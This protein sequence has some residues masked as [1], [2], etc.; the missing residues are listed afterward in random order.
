MKTMAGGL[1]GGKAIDVKSIMEP[2]AAAMKDIMQSMLDLVV[3]MI[4]QLMAIPL[5]VGPKTTK[6]KAEAIAAV[7]NAVASMAKGFGEMAG[8]VM[9]MN[10]DQQGLFSS[11]PTVQKTME[12]YSSVLTTIMEAVK[13]HIPSIVTTV[14]DA[15]MAIPGKP[16]DA[17][18]K[19]EVISLAMEA[20]GNFASAISEMSAL[21]P[22]DTG[23]WWPFGEDPEPL[24]EFMSTVKSIVD[25]AACHIPG[26]VNALMGIKIDKPEEAKVKMGVIADAMRA[27]AD[28]AKM[29]SSIKDMKAT[30]IS[31]KFTSVAT[32][33]VGALN[34]PVKSI[35]DTLVAFP[36]VDDKPLIEKINALENVMNPLI[37]FTQKFKT[38]SEGMKNM[39]GVAESNLV[40]NFQLIIEEMA[41]IHDI[42]QYDMP[43]LD[44]VGV[45][46]Q[47]G[48]NMSISSETISVNNK[49]INITVNLSLSMDA[50]EIAQGL[51]KRKGKYSVALSRSN[52]EGVPGTTDMQGTQ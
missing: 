20:V 7:I 34:T 14:M 2:Y 48:Q 12:D 31:G 10:A 28:F 35:V 4:T 33:V 22:K 38:F 50:D 18:A 39:E 41:M 40:T 49:P 6:A 37:R 5:T 43:S 52:G 17:K 26:I 25:V 3:P 23:S 32:A 36:T 30:D 11:G 27:T 21:I 44:L 51:S 42:L 45:L 19:L 8:G 13:C 9:Q 15:A 47:F 29:M 24:T 1:F 46:D 16:E